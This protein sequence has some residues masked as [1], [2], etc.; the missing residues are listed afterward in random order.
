MTC[1][2][3][4][5]NLQQPV[6][7]LSLCFTP[8]DAAHQQRH[9]DILGGSEFRQQVMELPN[10]SQLSTAKFRGCIFRELRQFDFGEVYV[11]FGSTIKNSEYVQEGAFPG[12]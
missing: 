7:G 3:R 12:T 8:V 10:K 9:G 1:T 5:P 4:Q 2:V 6:Q 11:T